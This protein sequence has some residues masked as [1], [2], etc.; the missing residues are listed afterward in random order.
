MAEQKTKPTEAS[1]EAY[2]DAIADP[3]RRDDCR[4][5]IALM[6]GATGCEPCLWGSSIVGFGSYHYRYASGHE[7]DAPLIGFASRKPDLTLYITP[8][9]ERYQSL[10]ARLGRHRVA[11]CCLYLKRLADVD[12]QVLGELIELSVQ[13]VRDRYPATGG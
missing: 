12:P 8:G 10:L 9:F 13:Q 6:R 1:I 11:K 5:L 4:A 7:G 3:A 2:V